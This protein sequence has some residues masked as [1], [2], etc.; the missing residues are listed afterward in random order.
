MGTLVGRAVEVDAVWVAVGEV[1]AMVVGSMTMVVGSQSAVLVSVAVGRMLVM[2]WALVDGVAEAVAAEPDDLDTVTNVE[3]DPEVGT[4]VGA[5]DVAPE[6]E[7]TWLPVDVGIDDDSVAVPLL[8]E[9]P[10]EPV[11]TAEEE[12][13]VT[14]TADEV[15]G[16]VGSP[17]LV[18]LETPMSVA[19]LVGALD[20]TGGG[21]VMGPEVVA[22]ALT[23]GS[24]LVELTTDTSELVG[25]VGIEIGIE[26]V[27]PDEVDDA[28]DEVTSAELVVAGGAVEVG[29]KG[30]SV[31]SDKLGK[32]PCE[33]VDFWTD[34]DVAPVPGSEVWTGRPDEVSEGGAVVSAGEVAGAEVLD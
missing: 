22:E 30:G 6:D 20:V 32:R 26:T 2:G 24:L 14:E 33:E 13:P 19:E 12:E 10:T 18:L 15:T 17:E 1:H 23:G 9:L 25:S 11:S 21:L 27:T 28:A 31:G 3:A 16:P 29:S 34:D 5:A 8:V 4:L 7:A